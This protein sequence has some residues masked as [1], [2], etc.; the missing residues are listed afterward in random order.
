MLLISRATGGVGLNI[1]VANV[2][3]LCGPW[4]KSEWERQ[5]IKRA[6]RPGQTRE[7]IAIRMQA[8][9]CALETYKA[10]LRDKKHR[11]DSKIATFATL[12]E[13]LVGINR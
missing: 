11:H 10:E 6:H 2:V 5:A 3:I 9:N 7:V 8:D 12:T 1:P 13:D 4:W